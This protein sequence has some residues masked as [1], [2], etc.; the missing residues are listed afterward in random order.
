M[1]TKLKLMVILTIWTT[2]APTFAKAQ[3]LTTGQIS[4]RVLEAPDKPMD[5]ATVILLRVAGAVPVKTVFTA[6]DGKFSFGQLGPGKYTVR[7]SAMG[8]HNYNSDSL[9]LDMGH[10][11]LELKT[12]TLTPAAK[13]L[14]E[15]AIVGQKAFVERKIDRTVVNVDALISNAG[16]TALDVIEKSPGIMIDQNGVISLKGKQGVMVL[17]DDKPT[18]LSGADLENYL[19]S[20]PSSSLSQI[21]I[22]TN[23]P[24]RYD[25]A[26]NAGVI[27]IKTK[28][29]NIRGFNGGVNLSLNQGQMA[30]SNN[31]LNFNY[32]NNKFNFFGN[33]GYNLNNSFTDLDINRTYLNEDG[34]VKSFFE[35]N[36]YFKRHGNIYSTKLGADYYLSEKS[37]LGLV[38]T[39]MARKSSQLNDNASNLLNSTR[40]LDS[41]LVAQNQDD[42]NYKNGGVNLNYRHQF[43]KKGTELTVDADYL[44][45]RNKTAQVYNNF[46]YLPDQQLK[47]QDLLTGNL[48]SNIDIYSLKADYSMAL[49]TDWKLGTGLKSSYTKTDN[50]AAYTTTINAVTRPDYDRS[51][52][53]IYKENINAAYL[54][55]SKET[56]KL[57]VQAGLRIEQT[58]SDGHQLGN[59]MKA[60][61][62]FKRNYTSVFPTF[63]ISYK[64]DSLSD[65]QLGLNYGRRIDRPYYQS[66]NPFI[67]SLDKFTYYVGNPFLKPSY[68]Q[69]IELSHTYKNKVTTTLSYNNIKDAV[70]ETIEILDG[71]Y[72]S[73]PGNLGRQ[74]I[75]SISVDAG[76]DLAKWLNLHVY[77]EFTNIT[78]K[79]DFYTGVLH[80]KGNFWLLNPL[81]LLK[82]DKGW[83]AE[84]SGSYRTKLYNAQF[85]LGHYWQAN[86]AV[87]K[88][89]SSSTT[90]K[91]SMNDIFYTRINTGVINNLANTKAGWTNKSD[92]RAAVLTL[93]YNF[94]K[95]ITDLRKHDATGAQSEQQRANN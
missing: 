65:N 78:S 23:P 17:I 74:V 75:K 57:S 52:H 12:I 37:T 90:L 16:T 55:L 7:V 25:A 34:S 21:E 58:V 85:I 33:L 91:L 53:F 15:V 62:S 63:Y 77:T 13:N 60:D 5:L 73:R 95:M 36:S 64:L 22:M 79:S 82:L 87:Q 39:G 28:K 26:G 72:Y 18:Y 66:L 6:E 88:K 30:R 24:A 93:S 45:Y 56:K 8:Y 84:L 83:N 29:G 46:S 43:D 86:V 54:N 67:N 89:I 10:L 27:N 42:I 51:N 61:S 59:A 41:V 48:P 76:F 20:L 80:T 11:T 19:R 9:I 32:R 68:I 4:G 14:Q 1:Y 38:L 50:T 44:T 81:L 49:K 92:T 71:I 40:V 35:Q 31:S 2:I 69:N 3:Q 70:N 47:S 94:G